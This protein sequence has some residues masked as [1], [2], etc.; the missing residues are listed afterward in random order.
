[1]QTQ[2]FRIKVA[3]EPTASKHLHGKTENST[4]NKL[5]LKR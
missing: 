3:K 2:S 4:T 5:R 1:M